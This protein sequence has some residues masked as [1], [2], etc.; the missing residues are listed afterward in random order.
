MKPSTVWIAVV[1]LALGVCGIL[2]VVGV[3]SSSQTIAQWWPLAIVG[4]AVAEMLNVRRV[5]LG[6]AICAAIGVT[7]LADAQA[8]A[9]GAV[10]WSALAITLGIVIL[11][12][13]VL[14]RGEHRNGGASTVV[15]GGA[16]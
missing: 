9:D 6:G 16:S 10:L 13:A 12:D 15:G 5:T 1:L 3:V 4:W 11:V 8:W 2:D 7:L 14:R